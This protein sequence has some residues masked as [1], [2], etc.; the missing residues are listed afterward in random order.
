MH[1]ASIGSDLQMSPFRPSGGAEANAPLA[2]GLAPKL[3]FF[4]IPFH[5]LRYRDQV[6]V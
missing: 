1:G 5:V 3:Q 6:A 4:V 2:S